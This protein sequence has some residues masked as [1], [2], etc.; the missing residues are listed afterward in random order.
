MIQRAFKLGFERASLILSQLEEA[1]VIEKE[2]GIMPRRILMSMEQFIKF[3]SDNI[4]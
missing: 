1:G 3:I 2:N 4:K